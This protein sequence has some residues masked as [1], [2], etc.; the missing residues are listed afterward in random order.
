MSGPQLQLMKILHCIPSL[1]GG[2]AE[3]QLTYLADALTRRGEDV[4]VATTSRGA[5]WDRLLA[6]GATAHELALSH[7]HDPR[8]L[9]ELRA[10]VARVEPDIVQVWLRQM[11]VV[12]GLAAISRRKPLVVSER[13]S[14]EAY[15]ASLKHFV[16][17]R[18]GRFA[19]AVVANS[20]AGAAYWRERLGDDRKLHVIPN[21]VPVEEIAQARRA[22]D[23]P[24]ETTQPLVLYAGRL[25]TEKNVDT[26]IA[27]FDVALTRRRFNVAICGTGTM[28]PRVA[29]WLQGRGLAGHVRLL[30]YTDDLWGL[31][32]RASALVSPALFE[33]NP[34]VVLEAMAARCPLVVS[35]IPAHRA[36]LDETSAVLVDP[37]SPQAIAEAILTTLDDTGAA[38]IRAE[39]AF[40]R[41]VHNR[42][43]AIAARY[44]EVYRGVAAG[45]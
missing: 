17:L 8:L 9:L 30:G 1:G 33:G 38:E 41:T 27:A 20:A 21:I 12:A 36:L 25:D 22:P 23:L 5:N 16:R 2:G 13:S 3:R 4:H 37:R 31:M 42:A 11:D 24:F 35:D 40:S 44:A 15:P 29:A 32:K 34:N 10:L 18:V 6:A 7:P 19:D 45:R 28:Q 43:E 14:A 39:A 26:L